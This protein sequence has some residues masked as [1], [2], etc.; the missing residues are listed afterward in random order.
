MHLQLATRMHLGCTQLQPPT[1]GVYHWSLPT[2]YLVDKQHH[3]GEDPVMRFGGSLLRWLASCPLLPQGLFLVAGSEVA[4]SYWVSAWKLRRAAKL[5]WA[6][7]VRLHPPCMKPSTFR[8]CRR[9]M[10]VKA[11]RS[12]GRWRRSSQAHPALYIRAT[13]ARLGGDPSAKVQRI[14]FMPK[15]TPYNAIGRVT[16]ASPELGSYKYMCIFVGGTWCLACSFERPNFD[17]TN[18]VSVLPQVGVMP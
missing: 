14:R 10:I 4:T 9:S 16:R 7:A 6:T 17:D 1:S 3:P 5:A 2:P 12:Q 11:Y 15:S 13:L 18:L 8:V